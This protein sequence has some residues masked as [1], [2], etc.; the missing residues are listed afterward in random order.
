MITTVLFD[1]DGVI[2]DSEPVYFEYKLQK[3]KEMG[4]PVTKEFLLS[5]IGESFRVMFPREFHVENPDKYVD[6][7]YRDS[8]KSDIDYRPLMFPELIDL[9]QYC[10]TQNIACYITSNSK[11]EHLERALKQLKI[12]SYF[13]KIYTNEQLKIAKPNPLFYQRVIEDL[14]LAKEEVIVIEDSKHGIAAAKGADLFTIA[15]K[16]SYFHIDQSQADMQVD[17]LS[18]VI[19]IIKNLNSIHKIN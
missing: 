5:R 19:D 10:Q 13:K 4:F 14:N 17:L 7:Y 1:F 6:E 8:K 9:L 11:Q 18:E 16:E 2:C 12:N 15:K 3:M